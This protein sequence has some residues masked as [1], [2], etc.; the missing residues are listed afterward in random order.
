MIRN[1]PGGSSD[2]EPFGKVTEKKSINFDLA[3]LD[4]WSRTRRELLDPQN[5]L[6][7]TGRTKLSIEP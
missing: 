3:N 2:D 4:L 5:I 7:P 6:I 1:N